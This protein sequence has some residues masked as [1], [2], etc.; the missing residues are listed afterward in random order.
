ME[1]DD[2]QVMYLFEQY[3]KCTPEQKKFLSEEIFKVFLEKS[4][5]NDDQH[6][7]YWKPPS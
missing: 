2:D 7:Q 4:R 5:T 6:P 3:L 1:L